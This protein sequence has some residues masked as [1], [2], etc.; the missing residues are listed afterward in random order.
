MGWLDETPSRAEKVALLVALRDITDGKIFVEA[1]RA[2]LTRLLAKVCTFCRGRGAFGRE[3]SGHA[4]VST[5]RACDVESVMCNVCLFFL[6][7]MIVA[8]EGRRW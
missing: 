7:W 6:L 3:D 1:E 5:D 8:D 2:K 4:G